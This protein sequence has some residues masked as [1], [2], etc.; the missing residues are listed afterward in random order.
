MYE[1]HWQNC[2][3]V[4]IANYSPK[5][6]FCEVS[7]QFE[8]SCCHYGAIS[9]E[10]K[11]MCMFLA[12]T[13]LWGKSQPNTTVWELI[14]ALKRYCCIDW[15]IG[16]DTARHYIYHSDSS[17]QQRRTWE[18]GRLSHSHREKCRAAAGLQM[19][20]TFLSSL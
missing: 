6:E 9:I 7:F 8:V 1:L 14:T 20:I 2:Y 10:W 3:K 15:L 16:R 19:A 5:M 12:D 4:A 13:I 17:L 11:Q 18:V